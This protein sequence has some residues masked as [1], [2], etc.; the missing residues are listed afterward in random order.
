MSRTSMLTETQLAGK[1]A[2]HLLSAP[3]LRALKRIERW[4]EMA[5]RRPANGTSVKLPTSIAATVV[6]FHYS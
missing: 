5:F 2:T 4:G 3:H 1:G 6:L